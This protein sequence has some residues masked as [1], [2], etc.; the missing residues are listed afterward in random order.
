MSIHGPG[1]KLLAHRQYLAF[2][3]QQAR[4][5]KARAR[6]AAAKQPPKRQ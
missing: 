2:K 4:A 5:R 6:Q 1:R 3:R